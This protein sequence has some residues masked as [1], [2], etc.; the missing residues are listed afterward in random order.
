VR[1][2]NE[3]AVRIRAKSDTD[4]VAGIPVKLRPIEERARRVKRNGI[5]QCRNAESWPDGKM[6]AIRKS[7]SL[8]DWGYPEFP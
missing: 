6:G 4:R 5:W 2:F 8:G 7:Q 1:E 3:S